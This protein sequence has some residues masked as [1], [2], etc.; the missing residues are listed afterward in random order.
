MALTDGDT[1]SLEN[2][3]AGAATMLFELE[4]DKVLENI[5]DP[6]T[7]AE[8]VREVHLV[9]RI[10]PDKDRST[11]SVAI[12]PSSKLAPAVALS[13]RMFFGKKAGRFMAWEHD[14]EQLDM[15]FDRGDVTVVTGGKT[16]AGE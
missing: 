12:I 15:G 9:V 11:G 16:A 8:K 3:K 1:V 13:T 5:M 2:L 14:P 7:D 4:L 10:K 6:N